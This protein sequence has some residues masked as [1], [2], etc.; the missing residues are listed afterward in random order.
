M[1]QKP[2]WETKKLEDM[3][4]AEWESLCDGCGKC[5]LFRLEGL[6]KGN[7]YTTNV[8]CKLFVE[9]TCQ[10]GDY[11]N[12]S[13]L[14]PTCLVLTTPLV[15]KLDWMPLTC[16]YRLL[17]NGKSLPWWHHL[18]SGSRDTVH[19]VGVSVRGKVEFEEDID[20]D[21]LEDHVVDWFD[22]PW[23]IL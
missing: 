22:Q 13:R 12:R 10:C 18:V 8:I 11:Q 7:Y 14:V 23:M 3:T 21:D 16:A 4:P 9:S 20:L 5:C 15:H 6:E 2:F 19:E 17:A 1:E